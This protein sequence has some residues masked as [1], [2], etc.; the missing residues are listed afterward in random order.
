MAPFA[1]PSLDRPAVGLLLAVL[2]PAARVACRSMI[3]LT[4]VGL[5]TGPLGRGLRRGR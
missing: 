4:A 5:A 2:R 1:S 3:A